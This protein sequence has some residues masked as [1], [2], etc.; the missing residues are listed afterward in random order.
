LRLE[1]SANGS[2]LILPELQLGVTFSSTQAETVST[3]SSDASFIAGLEL[4]K[5]AMADGTKRD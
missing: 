5:K 4:L 1:G 3:I 2:N